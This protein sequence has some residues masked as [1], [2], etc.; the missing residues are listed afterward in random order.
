[1]V[2]KIR[3]I[4][5]KSKELT[6][7]QKSRRKDKVEMQTQTAPGPQHPSPHLP[8]RPRPDLT[9]DSL[10][11]GHLTL[12][13]GGETAQCPSGRAPPGPAPHVLALGLVT[14]L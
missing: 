12:A 9:T 3:K 14:L 5:Y 1:M 10:G 11:A 4:I 7:P 13:V 8:G 2:L 6:Q